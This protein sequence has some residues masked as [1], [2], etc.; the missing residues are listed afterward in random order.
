[1]LFACL[2]GLF[3]NYCHTMACKAAGMDMQSTTRTESFE[4]CIK[5]LYQ[6]GS[7]C[8]Q[9]HLQLNLLSHLWLLL[10]RKACWLRHEEPGVLEWLQA[11]AVFL[12]YGPVCH[13]SIKFCGTLAC[14]LLVFW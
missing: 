2:L 9:Q 7:S 13:G 3:L 10:V 4:V 11:P 8:T 1:M 14:A 5:L 6:G 12:Q